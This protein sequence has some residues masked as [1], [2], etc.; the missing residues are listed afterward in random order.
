MISRTINRLWSAADILHW[1]NSFHIL[2]ECPMVLDR[3]HLVSEIWRIELVGG[4]RLSIMTKS[5]PCQSITLHLNCSMVAVN[6]QAN[7]LLYWT[8]IESHLPHDM[9]PEWQHNPLI[10][11]TGTHSQHLLQRNSNQCRRCTTQHKPQASRNRPYY[12]STTRKSA[13]PRS[14]NP[15]STTAVSAAARPMSARLRGVRGTIFSIEVSLDC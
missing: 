8:Q 14:Q 11:P 1:V 9:P 15:Q 7:S 6:S 13:K 3:N 5:M 10:T 2:V 12:S 4:S